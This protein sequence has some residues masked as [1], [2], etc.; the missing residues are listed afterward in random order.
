MSKRKKIRRHAVDR[1]HGA[2]REHLVVASLIAH[3]AGGAHRQEH[4]YG[5]SALDSRSEPTVTR[6]R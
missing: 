1:G 4:R 5:D 2:E 3:H 6:K